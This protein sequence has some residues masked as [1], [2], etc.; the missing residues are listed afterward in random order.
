MSTVQQ[1]RATALK[2]ARTR[3]RQ[4]VARKRETRPHGTWRDVRRKRECSRCGQVKERRQA[5]LCNA[6]HAAYQRDRRRRAR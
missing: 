5:G 1:R 4:A 2:A 6:C 3:R